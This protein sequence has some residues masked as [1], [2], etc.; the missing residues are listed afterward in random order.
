MET[1][2]PCFV[3]KS[4]SPP[5]DTQVPSTKK[6]AFLDREGYRRDPNLT[7]R[8]NCPDLLARHPLGINTQP[9]EE[10]FNDH[11]LDRYGATKPRADF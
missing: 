3:C 10:V 4:K 5:R 7:W 6:G 9:G 2:G 1:V 11:S 8:V